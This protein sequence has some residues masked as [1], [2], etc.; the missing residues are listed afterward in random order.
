MCILFADT[1]FLR[2]SSPVGACALRLRTFSQDRKREY[3]VNQNP[4]QIRS[5]ITKA[6]HASIHELLNVCNQY[7]GWDFLLQIEEIPSVPGNG[8]L[9]YQ[10][11]TL[12]G[13][14]YLLGDMEI[15]LLG[16][17]HPQHRRN[18]IGRSLLDA[19]RASCRQLGKERL[20]LITHADLPSGEAFAKAVGGHYTFSEYCLVFSG[21]HLRK[22]AASHDGLQFRQAEQ[23]EASQVASI[24][25]QAFGDS[26]ADQFA[27]IE[28]E[29]KKPQRRFFLIWLHGEPIGTISVVSV[30]AER[31]D[32]TTFGI[33]P[34]HRG[35]GY[36]RSIL[37]QIA[38][39]LL[40]ENWSQITINVETQ[41]RNALALYESSGF[42]QAE[43]EHYYT[44]DF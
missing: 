39:L 29:I 35:R 14:V 8:L 26:F 16:C 23:T 28:K 32:I 37:G 19:A 27:W 10:Q 4:V 6:D 2:L 3:L 30:G 42:Q 15:E 38:D 5:G 20:L 18:G 44:I 33:L 11:E 25:A 12:V 41:N 22:P 36:G 17:V 21:A 40:A 13:V 31:I 9:A 7:D 34:L 1:I 24:A 43:V